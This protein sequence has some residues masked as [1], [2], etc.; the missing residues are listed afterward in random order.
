MTG[1]FT[2]PDNAQGLVIFVHGSGSGRFSTR[3]RHVARLLNEAHF[4]TLLA[5]LLTPNI[6]LLAERTGHMIEMAQSREDVNR[7]PIGLF[8]ASTG[9]AAAIIAAAERPEQ[10]RAVVSRGGRG[11]LAAPW[12]PQ[13]QAPLLL[14]VGELDTAVLELH[15]QILPQLQSHYSYEIVPGATH[16]FEEPGTLDVV[17]NLAIAWFQRYL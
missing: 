1:D 8:G 10:V 16:L 15:E 12:L 13:L 6:P 4:A 5:D 7:L 17:A 14:I 11:D 3:N 9:A 2:V